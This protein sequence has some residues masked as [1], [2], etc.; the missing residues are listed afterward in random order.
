MAAKKPASGGGYAAAAGSSCAGP[1]TMPPDELAAFLDRLRLSSYAEKA[2]DWCDSMGALCVRE[3][4]ENW[5]EFADHCNLKPLERRRIEKDAIAAGAVGASESPAAAPKSVPTATPSSPSKSGAAAQSFG[6]STA[7][8]QSSTAAGLALY[9]EPGGSFF[10]PLRPEA[11]ETRY[12]KLEELGTGATATVCRC[13]KRTGETFACKSIALGKLKLQPNFQRISDNLH[14]EVHILFSLRHPRVVSLYDVVETDDYLHLVM[15]LVDGGELFD[16]IVSR[17]SFNEPVAR[18]V[19]LQIAEGLKYIHSKDI[20][21]RDL[22]PENILVDQKNSRKGLLE[23]KLS[24]FGHSKLI[25]D[26]YSTALTRVGTPQYWAPEVS[27]P[28]KAAQGYSQN[29]DL[30]SLGVVLYVMLV[31]SYPFDGVAKPIEHQ[32]QKAEINF[33]AHRALSAKVQELIRAL[34]KVKPKERLSLERC[35]QHEWVVIGG[36]TLSKLLKTCTES[37]PAASEERYPL[38]SNVENKQM[39]D[40]LRRD[41]Q[42]WT[43]WYRTAATI[44]HGEVVVTWQLGCPESERAAARE[45]IQRIL[46]HHFKTEHVHQSSSSFSHRHEPLASVPEESS[47]RPRGSRFRLLSHTLKVDKDHGAGLDLAAE[48]HGMRV[49]KIYSQPGQPGLMVNDLITKINDIPMNDKA[50][51]VEEIFGKHFA[52]GAI[53]AIKRNAP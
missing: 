43:V 29:V 10:G 33:P 35:L 25:N 2:K 3:V 23:I 20:V 21:Y 1:P 48:S 34:I 41:L 42:Q 39:R 17:G 37:E 22:K 32:I 30:W 44:R 49:N 14:R 24:D 11:D 28:A 15:E 36:G 4:Q 52:D 7:A 9:A 16:H 13:V 40:E 47:G 53:L 46:K 51:R 19:F 27:D 12:K 26:G 18:Y 45:E 5:E 8:A 31:G 50:E 6:S 38:P